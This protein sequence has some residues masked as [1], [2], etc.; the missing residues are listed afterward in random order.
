MTERHPRVFLS[1]AWSDR[2]FV[3][4]LTAEI[5]RQGGVPFTPADLQPADNV[6]DRIRREIEA[7]DLVVFVVPRREG[8]GK[9]ALFEIGAA[10]ALG[11]RILALVPDR[12]RSANTEVAVQLADQMLLDTGSKSTAEVAN[13]VITAA[14]AA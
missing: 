8:E 10:R 3:E 7:A 5:A 14:S 2:E 12:T 4:Q 11:K 9:T 1:A 13:S 6:F